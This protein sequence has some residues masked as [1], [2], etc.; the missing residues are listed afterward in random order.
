MIDE[1]D[2]LLSYGYGEDITSIG[3][4]LPGSVHTLLLSATITPELKSVTSLFLHNPGEAHT[5]VAPKPHAS[6]TQAA[7]KSHTPT[8]STCDTLIVFHTCLSPL[9]LHLFWRSDDRSRRGS[10]LRGGE[11]Q[12][13]LAAL[14]ALGQVLGHVCT[15]QTE[16][17]SW[18]VADL[19][20]FGRPRI[21]AQALPR[22]GKS[23][24]FRILT[25][26]LRILTLRILTPHASWQRCSSPPPPSLLAISRAISFFPAFSLGSLTR[27]L[28]VPPSPS[29]NLTPPSFVHGL[30]VSLSLSF[31]SLASP[32][33]CSTASCHSNRAGIAYRPST[34]ASSTS[35]WR[36]TTQG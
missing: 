26:R 27:H 9:G 8:L 30:T 16:P 21:S 17:D 6:R 28:F 24:T 31:D 4:A 22:T 33:V 15:L 19:C 32:L 18:T 13:V 14:L 7:R 2:L 1:A 35:S 34:G 23:L 29:C 5:Q 11:A 25:P 20:Q 3:Q 12:P 36:R 10:E